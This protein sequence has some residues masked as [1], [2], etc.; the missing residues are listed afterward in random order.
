MSFNPIKIYIIILLSS[1]AMLSKMSLSEIA[2]LRNDFKLE[3]AK[4]NI[5]AKE[6]KLS[7]TSLD[8]TVTLRAT[9]SVFPSKI[10]RYLK[11]VLS[12]NLQAS[13]D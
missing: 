11:P 2:Q 12:R 9:G 6:R 3:N 10:D 13:D 8:N 1:V 4:L 7:V 5:M